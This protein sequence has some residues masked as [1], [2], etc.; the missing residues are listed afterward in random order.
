MYLRTVPVNGGV[1]R[2]SPPSIISMK[3]KKGNP[4]REDLPG[5]LGGASARSGGRLS[6]RRS[7]LWKVAE[8]SQ[9]REGARAKDVDVRYKFVI[10]TS[11]LR[12]RER[13]FVATIFILNFKLF[14]L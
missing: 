3:R 11:K 10:D 13:G 4:R 12:E 9:C 1:A 8:A 14:Y 6:K 5:Y 7:F 2:I